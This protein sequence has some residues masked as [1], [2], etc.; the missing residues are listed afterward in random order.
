MENW[1]FFFRL[2]NTY[3]FIREG[4]T[5]T[6]SQG[7]K[8]D[9]CQ[10]LR[11]VGLTRSET[12]PIVDNLTRQVKC[13]GPENVVKRLKTLKQAAVNKLSGNPWQLPWIANR[14]NTPKGPWKRVWA[15]LDASSHKHRVRAFNAMMVYASLVLPKKACPTLSQELKFLGS[16]RQ[17]D[18]VAKRKEENASALVQTKEFRDVVIELR[19]LT[20]NVHHIQN[21]PDVVVFCQQR[22]GTDEIGIHKTEKLIWYFLSSEAGQH[23]QAFP[24]VKAA[25]GVTGDDYFE[26]TH[27][28]NGAHRDWTSKRLPLDDEILGTVGFTHEPGLKFRAFASPNRVLQA[29][30]EPMKH[31]LLEM[32]RQCEW[33]ATHDQHK[34]IVEVQ[35][36]ITDGKTCYSVDLS[37]A[38]NNFPLGVQLNVLQGLNKFPDSTLTLFRDVC[39]MAYRTAWEPRDGNRVVTWNV[40]QPLGAGPSFMSFA[41]AHYCI[42]RIAERRVGIDE[43]GSTF[44]ILGDDFITNHPG[45]H[46]EYRRI[47]AFLECPISESKCLVSREAGEF[48]GKLVTSNGVYG[49]FK[50]RDVS[51]LSFL[52]IVQSIGPQA[53]SPLILSKD[54]I[55]YCNL[56]REIPE[57]WGLG[58]NPKG[59]PL[60]DRYEEYLHFVDKMSLE[61]SQSVASVA[62]FHHRQHA[63]SHHMFWRDPRFGVSAWRQD[64][65]ECVRPSKPISPLSVLENI[66]HEELVPVTITS[67]DPRE[68]PLVKN[69]SN[70]C[71]LFLMQNLVWHQQSML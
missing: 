3:Q 42:A 40:G 44:R 11:L 8:D 39:R 61:P 67:G 28:W 53:I 31:T 15:K 24:E 32:L 17:P 19:N 21:Y 50:Y 59:R 4:M 35:K 68:N 47:L 48:A 69:I 26:L 23:F 22:L 18:C 34:A 20:N 58:F 63:F 71:L 55:Q 51:D 1:S 45:V 30:L 41:L 52:S 37:D 36:W 54:Q 16:V 9:L 65:V 57:S 10:K 43:P 56:V 70:W 5:M 66:R 14:N 6:I 49:G 64:S 46:T 13:E 33:D 7:L 27:P 62:E 38:T 12:L 2:S 60:K 25:L 29:A